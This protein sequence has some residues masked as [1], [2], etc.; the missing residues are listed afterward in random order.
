MEDGLNPPESDACPRVCGIA[1]RSNTCAVIRA[2]YFWGSERGGRERA[3]PP[4]PRAGPVLPPEQHRPRTLDW[5]PPPARR[6]IPDRARARVAGCSSQNGP[7]SPRQCR[8][9]PTNVPEVATARAHGGMV[10]QQYHEF[11]VVLRRDS[12]GTPWGFRLQGGAECQAPL[13]VQRVSRHVFIL[14]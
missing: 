9:R 6:R 3:R 4:R 14:H 2:A 13:T 8:A 7:S 1:C 11:E 12:A 5:K 10:G